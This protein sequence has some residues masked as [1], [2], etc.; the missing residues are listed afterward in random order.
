MQEETSNSQES[1]FLITQLFKISK[2]EEP[3][4]DNRNERKRISGRLGKRLRTSKRERS[5]SMSLM[6][7][8]RNNSVEK[9]SKQIKRN[10]RFFK[11]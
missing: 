9:I 6:R 4:N 7:P 8:S 11:N 2:L 5:K 10:I 3:K 1:N